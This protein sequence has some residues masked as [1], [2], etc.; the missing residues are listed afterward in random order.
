MK[1]EVSPSKS[2]MNKADVFTKLNETQ[3]VK[4]QF[5]VFINIK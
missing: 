2:S 4:L 1:K 3:I 5:D